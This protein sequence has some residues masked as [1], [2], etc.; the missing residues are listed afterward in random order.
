MCVCKKVCIFKRL[1]VHGR[2]GFENGAEKKARIA[3]EPLIVWDQIM[4]IMISSEV[5]TLSAQILACI[6]YCAAAA[7]AAA[8]LACVSVFALKTV[9]G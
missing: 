7:A 3:P 4:I 5:G 1:A 2:N 8:G 6:V 9:E